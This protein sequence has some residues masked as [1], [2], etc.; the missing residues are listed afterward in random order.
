MATL[1]IN[2]NFELRLACEACVHACAKREK[3]TPRM[4]V[5]S[6]ATMTVVAGA[7]NTVS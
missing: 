3:T 5:M 2:L 4:S 6:K 7:N 1:E